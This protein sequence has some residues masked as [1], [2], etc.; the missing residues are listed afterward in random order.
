MAAD[1]YEVLRAA[2]N[3][4]RLLTAS[5][6]E[7]E[8]FARTICLPQAFTHF[9]G[10]EWPQITETIRLMLLVR[11][12]EETQNESLV[13]SKRALNVA[14]LGMWL[15]AFQVFLV[16]VQVVLALPDWVVET[17]RRLLGSTP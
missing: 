17:I 8:R 2:V 10:P 14:R 1:K 11:I 5:R 3:E 7:L 12:S 13:V 16:C 6:T 9:S 15:V 4:G